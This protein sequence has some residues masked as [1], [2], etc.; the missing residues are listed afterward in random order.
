MAKAWKLAL[1]I[2][3]GLAVGAG[4]AAWSMKRGGLSGVG[5]GGWYG[6]LLILGCVLGWGVYSLCSK[7]LNQH[8]GPLQTVT[9]SILMGTLMLWVATLARGERSRLADFASEAL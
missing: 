5:A 2:A 7:G 3:A 4:S 6:D 9:Y 8:L 1:T